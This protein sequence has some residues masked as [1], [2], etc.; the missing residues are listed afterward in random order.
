MY[1][2]SLLSTRAPIELYRKHIASKAK[3][4]TKL[5][6][7]RGQY[8]VTIHNLALAQ[9][10][11]A[12]I[13]LLAIF[14]VKNIYYHE[15]GAAWHDPRKN[16]VKLFRRLQRIDLII[17]NSEATKKLLIEYYGITKR[18]IVARSPV[19]SQKLL[20]ESKL[21]EKACNLKNKSITI[22][23]L[24]RQEAH[25]NPCFVIDL[26]ARMVELGYNVRV[27]I[28]GS[29]TLN[30]QINDLAITKNIETKDHGRVADW[31]EIVSDWDLC[32]APSI[33]EPLGLVPA[34]TLR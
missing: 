32:I 16:R 33:R 3:T 19:K 10:W 4:A 5:I 34:S 24:G 29:G 30:S 25:K 31:R 23:Y 28:V 26:A 6:K 22:G 2:C 15:H 8:P 27:E 20:S 7:N 17:A 1:R 14:R 18:I 12:I 11:Y 9:S 13:V 21:K